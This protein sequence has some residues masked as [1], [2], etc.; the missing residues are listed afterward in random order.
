M[1][2]NEKCVSKLI[3]RLKVLDV[4]PDDLHSIS[5]IHGLR[6][7]SPESCL[8]TSTY[9]S[10]WHECTLNHTHKK[11]KTNKQISKCGNKMQRYFIHS[12]SMIIKL[13]Y[14]L[15][16]AHI[17]KNFMSSVSLIQFLEKCI[18]DA[19][20]VVNLDDLSNMLLFSNANTNSL[21]E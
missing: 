7:P 18:C 21:S 12:Y 13:L 19:F 6:R 8:L 2:Q 1:L 9:A 17:M 16:I 11:K 5:G 15:Y 20:L 3:Q 14:M 10:S 4:K